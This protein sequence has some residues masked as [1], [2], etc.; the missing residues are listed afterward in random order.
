MNRIEPFAIPFSSSAVQ[1]LRDRLKRTRWPDALPESNEA[2]G[3]D[4]E[5]L[6]DLC[7]YWCED[8]DWKAQVDRLSTL[9]HFRYQAEEGAVHFLHV[10]GKGPDPMPLILT[11]GWPGSFVEMLEILPLLTDPAAHGGD[12]AD[13][14]DV[15]IPSLPGFGFSDRPRRQGMNVFRVAEVWSELMTA[16]G[17]ERFAAQGGDL[18][19]GVTTALGLRHSE[20]L[21]GIHLNYIPGSYKPYLGDGAVL[22][23]A[24]SQF[25]SNAAR[26]YDSNGAYAHLQATRPQTPAYALND[27]PVGLAAWILEK[28]REWSDCDGDVYRSFSR[29][30]LL[31]NVTLYWM[32]GTIASSFLMYSEG[33][34][35]PLHFSA[36]DFVSTPTAVACFPK[37]ISRPPRE[38]VER[39][40][41]VQR[42]TSM[43]RGGHFAAAEEPELLAADLRAFFRGLR[44]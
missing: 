42:W 15:V 36:E 8:F 6:I 11:H 25:L 44:R 23:E 41:D 31:T 17:Y 4:R 27:S 10:R 20:R 43:P 14:F 21:I 19:A 7:R 37:E 34:K 9:P 40:F 22:T 39:G 32:T 29:D 35:R 3:V 16:L 5:F 30:E 38:W 28:F 13:S 33:R 2:H 1:D 12:P 26:W 18:G 24:E